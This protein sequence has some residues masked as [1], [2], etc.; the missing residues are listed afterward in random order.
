MPVTTPT[1]TTKTA[2]SASAAPSG[3]CVRESAIAHATATTMVATM[4]KIDA[5]AD[6][7]QRHPEAENAQDRHAAHQ[8]Q[9]IF[10]GEKA[11]KEEREAAEHQRGKKRRQSLPASDANATSFLPRWP[12][13]A[14]H[15]LLSRCWQR[16]QPARNMNRDSAVIFSLNEHYSLSVVKAG[17]AQK[18]RKY[19]NEIRLLGSR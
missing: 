14:G 5:A 10:D 8:R 9:K 1:P 3:N 7:D 13:R 19:L 15:L 11:G 6:D 12:P 4:A 17:R 2:P 18:S 16:G